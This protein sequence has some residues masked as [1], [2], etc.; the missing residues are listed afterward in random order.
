MISVAV[1]RDREVAD[2]IDSTRMLFAAETLSRGTLSIILARLEK[3]AARN[4]FWAA[5]EYADAAPGEEGPLYLISEQPD[6]SLAL[7]LNI[8]T[9]GMKYPPHNHTTWACVASVMGA[10][11]NYL[12]DRMD[13]RSVPGRADI[14]SV[15]AL[16]R[17]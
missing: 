9:P 2:L 12:F 11:R 4:E 5:S 15:R 6:H 16:P 1:E 10:E 14:R 8:L 3:L 17:R 7:Y 13:D